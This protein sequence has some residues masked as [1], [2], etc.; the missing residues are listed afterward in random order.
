MHLSKAYLAAS[1]ETPGHSD[2]VIDTARRNHFF[3]VG[4][5]PF[6]L[7]LE[8]KEDEHALDLDEPVSDPM[9]TWILMVL[10]DRDI[11][12]AKTKEGSC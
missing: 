9:F 10:G 6:F 12:I 3:P 8:R 7:L 5:P 11:I 4:F 1:L 2:W